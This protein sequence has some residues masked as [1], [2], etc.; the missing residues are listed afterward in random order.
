MLEPSILIRPTRDAADLSAL[1]QRGNQHR[2]RQQQFRTSLRQIGVWLH[3]LRTTPVQAVRR[4]PTRYLLHTLVLLLVPIALLLAQAPVAL[5][6]ERA[7][8]AAPAPQLFADAPVAE[9]P[10]RALNIHRF[11]AAATQAGD[12]PLEA[13]AIPVPLSL[14]SRSDA[15]VPV[16][17][18]ASIRAEVEAILRGGPSTEYDEV[19]RLDDG[20][21]VLVVGRYQDWLQVRQR[22][23]DPLYWI[24]A[25]LL[26]LNS[27]AHTALP[28]L[29]EADIPA[30]PPPRIATT[31]DS[32]VSLRDGP[33][34]EYNHLRTLAADVELAIIERYDDWLHVAAGGTQGWVSATLVN[35][36]EGVLERVPV[37]K[38]IPAVVPQMTATSIPEPEIVAM[39]GTILQDQANL[40]GG[41]GTVYERVGTLGY[42]EPVTVL[43]QHQEWY[44]IQTNGGT[45]GWVFGNLL[46]LD[47]RVAQQVPYTNNI[48]APPTPTPE[49]VQAA[50]AAPV[51]GYASG[52]AAGVALQF[53]GY[54]YVWGGASPGTGF[55]CSGLMVYAYRQI[56]VYL[57][58][59]AAM[60]YSTGV[61]APVSMG[62]L[63]PGDL[64][65]FAGTAGP[66][67]THV[68]MYIGGGSVVHAT[69]PAYGVQVSNLYEPYWMA[70]YY[71]AI[72]PYR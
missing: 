72:R 22:A 9:A 12:P 53:V 67:I 57:P 1:Q 44:Q 61:G 55:D 29:T 71:G 49:P 52:D 56:G 8:P 3:T 47:S 6:P 4:I 41:P 63:A 11:R 18:P 21:S 27:V 24:A 17:V 51:Y 35:M 15:L 10:L 2:L 26:E 5:T 46:G 36:R 64:V 30:P 65:F 45:Q 37:A 33:G 54:P 28:E 62:G 40:R 66:G 43:A 20:I 68:A 42:G 38:S 34:S 32:G 48:P 69:T 59:N 70:H 14:T 50:P 25:D 60:M 7:A 19:L 39:V 13:D 58:H 23:G 31:N 16:I